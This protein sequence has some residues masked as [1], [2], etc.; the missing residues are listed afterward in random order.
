MALKDTPKNTLKNMEKKQLC[1]CKLEL[2]LKFM[3]IKKAK[4][5]Q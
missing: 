3:A 5:D 1:I 2:S 4:K